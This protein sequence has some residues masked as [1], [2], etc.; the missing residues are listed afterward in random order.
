MFEDISTET[1]VLVAAFVVFAI[2]MIYF[3]R[4]SNK[5]LIKKI[6]E[7]RKKEEELRKEVEHIYKVRQTDNSELK[8]RVQSLEDKMSVLLKPDS[9]E[10]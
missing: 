7:V 2:L 5:K 10:K 1:M 4:F 3:Y 6:S 9:S 8:K